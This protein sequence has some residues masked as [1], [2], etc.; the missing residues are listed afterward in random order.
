MIKSSLKSTPSVT[1]KAT[2]AVQSPAAE[3]NK[4]MHQSIVAK[5]VKTVNS[6]VA[7]AVSVVE[8]IKQETKNETAMIIDSIIMAEKKH[9]EDSFKQQDLL[10]SNDITDENKDVVKEIVSE[11]IETDSPKTNG[12]SAT[13]EIIAPKLLEPME[14]VDMSASMIAKSRINTEEEAKAAIAEKRRAAREEAQRLAELERQRIEAELES[15][16]QRQLD[17]EENQRN[18]EEES[19]RMAQDQRRLEEER[20]QQAIEENSKR[21][22]EEKM[23]KE[24]EARE[25]IEREEAEQKAREDAEKQKAEMAER[26]RKEEK[27]REE[28]RKRVEAIMSRTRAKGSANNT[29]VKV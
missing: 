8:E 21:D 16:R 19:L 12:T 15:E 1:P 20:L 23:K 4:T 10:D 18:L 9:T 14:S 29:P 17:E 13:V 7:S 3:E 2:S 25:K 5:G 26:L 28:R 6:V 24:E 11:V 22:A 27:E